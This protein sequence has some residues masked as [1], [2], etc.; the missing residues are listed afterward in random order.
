M[1][2]RRPGDPKFEPENLA[3]ASAEVKKTQ[4]F[5]KAPKNKKNEKKGK[6]KKGGRERKKGKRRKKKKRKTKNEKEGGEKN[7]YILKLPIIRA[8]RGRYVK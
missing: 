7:N 1:V 2:L 5:E 6:N 8:R 3:Q 4:C